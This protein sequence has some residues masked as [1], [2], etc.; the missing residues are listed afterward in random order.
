[1][2][3]HR[4][5]IQVKNPRRQYQG[6]ANRAQGEHFEAIIDDACTYY[7]RKGVASIEK[8]PE[9]MRP[10]KDL[11]GGKFIA[12]YKKKAQP[13]YTGALNG[14]RAVRFEAKFTSTEKMEQSRVSKEQ[15]EKLDEFAA[16]GAVC[17]VLVAFDRC[18]YYRIPWE[19]WR[20]MKERYGRLY[21]KPEDLEDYKLPFVN[22]VLYILEDL[23]K[24]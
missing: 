14:G 16:L 12:H 8:T 1:M 11:G 17:F 5:P 24:Q 21:I 19:V 10:T 15:G 2:S 20:A 18:G 9:P 23:Q 6:M 4:Q 7:A 13:D 22:G 3:A